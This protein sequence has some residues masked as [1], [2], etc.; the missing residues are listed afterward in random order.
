MKIIHWNKIQQKAKRFLKLFNLNILLPK[1]GRKQSLSIH[2]SLCY[3][4]FKHKHGIPTKKAVYK[5]FKPKCTYK[6]FV[7]SMNKWS[8]IAALIIILILKINRSFQHPIKHIDS[9]NIPVCLFK[10]AKNHKTMAGIA[11]YGNSGQGTFFGLKLHL[12]SDLL[13]NIQSLLFTS[14]RISDKDPNTVLKLSKNIWGLLI[15]DAGYVSA[16]LSRLF[17]QEGLRLLIV[18][19]YKNMKKLATKLQGL[20]YGTRMMIESHFRNLK[21]FHGLVTSLPRSVL[22]YFGNYFYSILSYQLS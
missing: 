4:L 2:E 20:L 7:V 1:V 8:L 12:I 3:G 13:M 16:K 14:G 18:K 9:T 10:N 15:G 22:G 11:D 6:T 21:M 5:M 17:N 19:P